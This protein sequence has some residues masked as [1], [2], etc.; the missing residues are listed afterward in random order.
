[1]KNFASVIELERLVIEYQ[2]HLLNNAG[3]TASSCRVRLVHLRAF[4]TSQFKPKEKL[5][6]Q[7]ITPKLLLNY[8]LEQRQRVCLETLQ[9]ITGCLRSFCRFL[10]FSGYA[11]RDLSAA[12]SPA[13]SAIFLGMWFNPNSR[14]SRLRIWQPWGCKSLHAH[15]FHGAWPQRE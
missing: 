12:E 3:L 14:G 1:M 11:D 13:G 15:Q 2:Q 5:D 4:L 7:K 9:S 8:V 10:C 6:L